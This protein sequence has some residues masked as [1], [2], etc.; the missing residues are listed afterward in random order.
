MFYYIE[1]CDNN[2]STYSHRIYELFLRTCTEIEAN[3]KGILST[4]LYK[5][6]G[7]FKMRDYFK[8]ED[9][10]KLSE[11]E[12][13]FER[14]KEQ[15]ALRPFE[16]WNSTT[17]QSLPWYQAYNNVKHNRY[18][19]FTDANFD[20]LMNSIGAL[21]IVLH[22]QYGEDMAETCFSNISLIQ[23]NQYEVHTDTFILKTPLFTNE[24]YDFI[25]D[26]IK[27]ETD[28]VTNYKF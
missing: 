25:W 8:V 6:Q 5:K 28:P 1:P 14:W 10:S 22:A 3:F 4:N 24:E 12:I 23:N 17:Y 7:D 21:L 13:T 11:Y 27:N 2:K 15:Y 26:D 20:N 19:N 16:Q 18:N 9:F